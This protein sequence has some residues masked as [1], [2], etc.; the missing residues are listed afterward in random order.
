MVIMFPFV[1]TFTTEESERSGPAV[2]GGLNSGPVKGAVIIS[3][4]S[5][6]WKAV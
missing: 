5:F 1:L 4:Y 6:F 2:Y 3:K